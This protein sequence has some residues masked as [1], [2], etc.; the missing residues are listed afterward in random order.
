MRRLA[1]LVTAAIVAAG[2][3]I[4][5]GRRRATLEALLRSEAHKGSITANNTERGASFV[6]ALPVT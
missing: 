3:G 6:I 1:L 5:L 4:Y 2:F